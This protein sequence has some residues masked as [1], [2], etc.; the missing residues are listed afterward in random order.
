M[1]PSAETKMLGRPDAGVRG[2]G[3]THAEWSGKAG[4]FV[5]QRF[6]HQAATAPYAPAVRFLD[7]ALSYDA[8]N[9]RANYL[10][11]VL[12]QRGVRP[13]Q[14]VVVCLEP[15]LDIA[16]ALLGILKAG[17][18]YVP[19]D[20]GYP[21]A[22]VRAI[23][24]DTQPAVVLTEEPLRLKFELAETNTLSLAALAQPELELEG[25]PD[26][27]PVADQPASVFYTSGSTGAP[28]GVV[29]SQS[30]LRH[31][32]RVAQ[33]AYRIGPGDVMPALARFSFS[34]SLF[35]LLTPLVSGATLRILPRAE[36]IDPKALARALG[37]VTI[38]HAGPS[39]LKGLL[40]YIRREYASFE[41]FAGVKHASSGGDMVPPEVLE[42]LKQVFSNAEVFVI[43]G[44]SEISCMGCTYPVPRDRTVTKTYVGKAFEDMTVRVLAIDGRD[45]EPGE[46]GEIVFAGQGVTL[47]YLERADLTAERFV[48]RDGDRY[49][50]TGDLGRFNPEGWLE[51]LGR[52]DFQVKIRGMRVELAEVESELRR[53]PGVLDAV[54]AAHES[55]DGE[56]MLI[57]YVVP[58][59][60]GAAGKAERLNA[61]RSHL[62]Q[63]LPDY[64]VPA[65]YVELERLPLNFNLKLDRRALPAPSETDFRALASS[66]VR[67]PESDSERTLAACFSQ[68]LKLERIG[69]DDNFFE[70]GGD[71]L[72]AVELC[73]GVESALGVRLEGI[74][75]LRE[76][77][78]V[79]ARLCD[80]KLGKRGA[81]AARQ[82]ATR[83]E[84]VETFH[85][86]ADRSLYG[87]LQHADAARPQTAALLCGAVGQEAVRSRFV[88][89]QLARSLA[90]DGVPALSFDYFGCGDSLGESADAAATRWLDDIVEAAEEL[91]RRTQASR[92]VAVGVRLGALLLCHAAGRVGAE[93]LVFWDPVRD[94][95]ECFAELRRL[96]R[97]YLRAMAPLRLPNFRWQQPPPGELLGT[98][99]SESTLRVLSSYR[100]EPVARDGKDITRC[101]DT[102][103]ACGWFDLAR[104][105][106]VVPDLGI[107]SRLRSLLTEE[108]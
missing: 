100:L 73:L 78:E 45:A 13:G 107:S 47:G 61:I 99:Y 19:V 75:L 51:M 17:A 50:R 10:A 77:L 68:V 66:A 6:E 55:A 29:S 91:R 25:N 105:E 102:E 42:G 87:V 12:Q 15:S 24:E 11:R 93:R 27:R 86:G 90:R 57:A 28:K 22:R 48:L 71:S 82:R 81:P 69:L 101:L 97:A 60:D 84:R 5:H 20:P 103:T 4:Q 88:L 79:L 30:N 59:H 96:R 85:F 7:R 80:D 63:R 49:Y 53:A 106:D 98:H 18:V 40:A 104:F 94:G 74:D 44:C 36:V 64:M 65:V 21:S 52:S 72:R 76:P 23:L 37:E 8:L 34:I 16:V 41:D 35:E 56:R 14:R 38:F 89:K 62:A 83:L 43:Y 2:A 31:Y 1:N 46:V 58:G 95:G 26:H 92:I 3:D 54:A 108:T 33:Q 32:V 67:E 9:R 39:L 70:L